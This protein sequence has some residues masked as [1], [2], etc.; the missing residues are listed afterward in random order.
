MSQC[1]IEC[2]FIN[3]A[4]GSRTTIVISPRKAGAIDPRWY[5]TD[6]EAHHQFG[7]DMIFVGLLFRSLFIIAFALGVLWSS[8]PAGGEI[9]NLSKL[10]TPDL[11]RAIL[12]IIICIAAVVHVFIRPKDSEAYRTWTYIGVA[13]VSLLLAVVAIKSIG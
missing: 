3:L 8:M 1:T 11:I 9:A 6:D 12:G 13:C 10:P 2:P 7:T 4:H 5:R